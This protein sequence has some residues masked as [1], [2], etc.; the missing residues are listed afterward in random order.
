MSESEVPLFYQSPWIPLAFVAGA[1]GIAVLFSALSG[2]RLLARR[3]AAF[4]G[5]HFLGCRLA[6][7]AALS[8]GISR[9]M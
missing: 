2:W 3:P 4:V 8:P 7:G 6:I 1:V 5:H 9:R